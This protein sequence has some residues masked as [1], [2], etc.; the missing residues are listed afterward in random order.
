M[1]CSCGQPVSIGVSKSGKPYTK[2]KA[3]AKSDYYT[4][5]QQS[6]DARNGALNRFEVILKSA[7]NQGVIRSNSVVPAPMVVEQHANMMDDNSP[8]VQ[9]W[10]EPNGVCGFGWVQVSPANCSFANWLKTKGYKYSSYDKAV[11]LHSPLMTQ[12][13]ERNYSWACGV[14]D[15]LNKHIAELTFGATKPRIWARERMD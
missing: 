15:Y 5:I 10:C 11:L 7:L 13:L 12:S 14:A 1:N 6:K 8:V 4:M 2:C 3:C 9:Q